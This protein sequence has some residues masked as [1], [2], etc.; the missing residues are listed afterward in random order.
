MANHGL[1]TVRVPFGYWITHPEPPFVGGAF[2]YLVKLFKWC[3]KHRISVILDFHGLKGSQNGKF[4]SGN[5]GA[6][7]Q[8]GC[9]K[10]QVDFLRHQETNLAVIAKLLRHFAKSPSYLGFGVANE[11]GGNVNSRKVMAFYQK[12]YDLIR[13]HSTDTLVFLDATFNPSTH[14]FVDEQGVAQGDH[15]YFSARFKKEG[16]ASAHSDVNFKLAQKKLMDVIR[17]PVLV[18]EWALDHHDFFKKVGQGYAKEEKDEWL[19]DFGRAQLQAYEQH[20]MGWTYWS[21]KTQHRASTWNYR[22]L[23]EE[24]FLPGCKKELQFSSDAW[25]GQSVCHYA[26]LDGKCNA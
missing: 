25:W 7:G 9:G 20:S 6:C 26:Y 8:H 5:C 14:P 24:G 19:H 4:T 1:N 13:Q 18:G 17:W 22:Y 21:Y 2:K 12:A 23:C 11:V 15:V 16:G 3:E 10:T